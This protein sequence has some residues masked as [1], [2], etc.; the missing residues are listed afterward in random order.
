MGFE[1]YVS[2]GLQ[3]HNCTGKYTTHWVHVP[4]EN[5]KSYASPVLELRLS[6]FSYMF[7]HKAR[8]FLQNGSYTLIAH[9]VSTQKKILK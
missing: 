4:F 3:I 6:M 7:R 8:I 2:L 1:M 5:E 9:R